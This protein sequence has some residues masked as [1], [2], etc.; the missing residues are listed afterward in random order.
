MHAWGGTT[1]YKY[2]WGVQL[3]YHDLTGLPAELPQPH[4]G[5]QRD[6]MRVHYGPGIFLLAPSPN[7]GLGDRKHSIKVHVHI[8]RP[9]AAL[10]PLR[11]RE[12]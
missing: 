3:S 1:L 10:L 11:R 4:L 12:R 2:Y 7:L 5:V 8:A 6:T 9:V